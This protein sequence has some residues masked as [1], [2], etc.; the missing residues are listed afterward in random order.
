MR[1]KSE[2]EGAYEEHFRSGKIFLLSLFFGGSAVFLIILLFYAVK[3]KILPAALIF[4]AASVYFVLEGFR[5]LRQSVRAKERKSKGNKAGARIAKAFSILLFLSLI[6]LPAAGTNVTYRMVFGRKETPRELRREAEA[7]EALKVKEMSF[8]SYR[9]DRLQACRYSAASGPPGEALLLFVHGFGAGGQQNYIEVYD[10]F[11]RRGFEVLAFD[12]TGNDRSEGSGVR[13]L[14][15]APADL[16]ACLKLVRR[17]PEL[18]ELPLFLMGHSWGAYAVMST[19]C[20]FP[21]V[22]AVC[23][24]SGMNDSLSMMEQAG[25]QY[26]GSGVRLL[27]PYFA[28]YEGFHFGHYADFSAVRGM[29]KSKADFLLVQGARDLTVPIEEGLDYFASIFADN[30]RF[31]FLRYEQ[32]G[33]E[34][35][36][37]SAKAL[38]CRKETSEA[39]KAWLEAQGIETEGSSHSFRDEFLSYMKEHVDLKKYYAANEVFLEDVYRF[40]EARLDA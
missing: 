1:K 30:E 40:F 35:M 17:S 12:I 31:S 8:E 18:K 25:S 23:A 4:S 24:V 21:E 33:H 34:A 32:Y 39:F 37:Y 16:E 7:F 14:P 5:R 38:A 3:L 9:G 20:L 2:L 10:F 29:E 11:V 27:L 13:G 15:Q 26:L 19:A 6:V 36:F 22:R 28:L